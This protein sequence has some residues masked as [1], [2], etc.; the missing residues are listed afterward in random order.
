MVVGVVVEA[1]PALATEATSGHELVLDA[2]GLE[3][4]VEVEGRPHRPGHRGV[5]VVADEVHQ[6]EWSHPEPPGRPNHFVDVGGGGCLLL[7]QAQRL[8]VEAAGDPVDDEARGGLHLSDF[9]APS[10]GDARRP[11]SATPGSVCRPATTSTSRITG[12]G[13]KK[14]MPTTRDGIG[15]RAAISVTDSEEVLVA[16]TQSGP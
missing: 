12:A 13:L 16:S 5:D 1:V 3:P 2:G 11:S 7:E 15:V 4:R 6:L 8:A 10:V 9:L 14:C